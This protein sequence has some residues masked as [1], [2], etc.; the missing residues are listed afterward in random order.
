MLKVKDN[1]KNGHKTHECRA[2][3]IA[4]ETQQHV[5]QTCQILH[6]TGNLPKVSEEKI[7]EENT[8]ALK[9]TAKQI[10]EILTKFEEVLAQS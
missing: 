2:C 8:E 9:I 10:E 5:L 6:N 4:P 1:Y 7:F 3:K